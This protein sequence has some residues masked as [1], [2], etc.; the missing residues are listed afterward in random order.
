MSNFILIPHT[1]VNKE[2][3]NHASMRT[4]LLTPA[5]L[6]QGIAVVTL[7][8]LR[9]GGAICVVQALE[10]LAGARIAC[11]GVLGVDIATALTWA[12]LTSQALRVT[13]VTRGTEV[14]ARA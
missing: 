4:A 1:D 5:V 13:I 10:A 11:I 8:A 14:T 2:R 6:C 7:L 3:C 9:T 12:A